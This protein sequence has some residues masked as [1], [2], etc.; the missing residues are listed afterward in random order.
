MYAP[1]SYEGP[2]E[3]VFEPPEDITPPP[4]VTASKEE[5]RVQ[6]VEEFEILL[7][8]LPEGLPEPLWGIPWWTLGKEVIASSMIREDGTLV[9]QVGG[10]TFHADKRDMDTFMQ[11][12]EH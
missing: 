11:E 9:C 1:S 6:S 4:V 10:R 12:V 2:E 7:Q 3:I 8:E 5:W